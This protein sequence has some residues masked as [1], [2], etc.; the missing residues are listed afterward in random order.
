MPN[1]TAAQFLKRHF[2]PNDRLAFVLVNRRSDAVIQRL[3][4]ARQGS[5]PEFQHW[6]R[7]HNRQRFEIYFSPNTLE[8]S[9]RGRTKSDIAEVRHIYLDFDENGTANLNRLLTRDDIPKP[10]FV[11]SSSPD[12]WQA[13]WAVQEF[14]K[15]QAEALMRHLVRELGAD[16]AATDVSRVMRL[17]GFYNQK[18]SHRHYVSVQEMSAEVHT[19]QRF[20]VPPSDERTGRVMGASHVLHDGRLSQ[21]E[22]DYAYAKRALYRGD[23]P[24]NIVAAIARYREGEKSDV[25]AYAER[26][27]RK[28]ADAVHAPREAEEPTR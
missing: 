3:T 19:P 23:T 26:T 1:D 13:F 7:E 20:P 11:V 18:Y 28:A 25:W 24:E 14:A 17:P 8:A 4:E 16:P 2:Q 22:L 27:V 5:S 12:H 15:E 21:S 10:N 6:L 9:A